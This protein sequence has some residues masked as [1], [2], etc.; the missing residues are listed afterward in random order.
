MVEETRALVVT[1]VVLEGRWARLE[2]L[3][4]R[5]I[6]D[7]AAVTGDEEIWRYLPLALTSTA[8]LSAWVDEALALQATGTVLPFAIIDR[9]SGRAIGGTRYLNIT[10]RDR[11]LEI[12]WTWLARSAWRTALNSECKLLLLRHAFETLGCIRV[13]FKTDRRNER[14]RQAI[15]RLGA[16]FEGILRQHMIMRDGVYRDSV[17]YSIIDSEWPAVKERLTRRLYDQ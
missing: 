1:P 8:R 11:G 10:P 15:E 12:G 13:Q 4:P 3:D 6:D 17:F 7:L 2:P 14:S 9:A 16:Q 5:H